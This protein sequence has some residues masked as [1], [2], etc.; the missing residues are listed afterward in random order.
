MSLLHALN[1]LHAKVRESAKRGSKIAQALTGEAP[2]SPHWPTI[3]HRWKKDHP[4]C[5]GCG[6]SENIQVHHVESF[7]THPELELQD[8]SGIPPGTGPVGGVPNFISLCMSEKECHLRIGHGGS[9]AH[10]GYNPNVRADAAEA[11]KYPSHRPLVEARSK[12]ARVTT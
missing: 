6:S 9:F 12:A 7:A 2:R 5:E 8:C 3:E 11:F 10:G 4:D 1:V